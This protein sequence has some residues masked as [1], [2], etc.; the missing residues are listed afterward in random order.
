MLIDRVTPAKSAW[1]LHVPTLLLTESVGTPAF[2]AIASHLRDQ[3]DKSSLAT[4]VRLDADELRALLRREYDMDSRV[5]HR[6][7]RVRKESGER[8]EVQHDRSSTPSAITSSITMQEFEDKSDTFQKLVNEQNSK[9]SESEDRIRELQLELG[10]FE[11][12]RE[13]YNRS[14]A[15]GDD[16]ERESTRDGDGENEEFGTL[17]SE[18]TDLNMRRD[19][20]EKEIEGFED[21]VEALKDEVSRLQSDIKSEEGRMKTLTS[22]VTELSNQHSKL[23][24]KKNELEKSLESLRD[25]AREATASHCDKH[26]EAGSCW[27][28]LRECNEKL[29]TF[30][31]EMEDIARSVEKTRATLDG[32]MYTQSELKQIL[33]TIRNSIEIFDATYAKYN[34]VSINRETVDTV[35][36]IRNFISD[37]DEIR[38]AFKKVMFTIDGGHDIVEEKKS[39]EIRFLQEISK[40]IEA[41]ILFINDT[42]EQ[43]IGNALSV[44][45]KLND[46]NKKI[47]E[48]VEAHTQVDHSVTR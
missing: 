9:K 22:D 47:S 44:N 11:T 38:G 42:F 34:D 21:Q 31:R 28:Q 37:A 7:H 24:D 20:L 33:S 43:E 18:L 19:L 2:D 48:F 46:L 12:H 3:E 15:K 36:Y 26:A 5:F 23:S 29:D 13:P 17:R 35:E 10:I 1:R 39:E 25:N 45:S 4:W 27:D 40:D 30:N 16:D 6:T 41:Q 8:A 32:Q 14:V